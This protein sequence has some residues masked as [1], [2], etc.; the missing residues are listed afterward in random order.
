MGNP[1]PPRLATGTL[2]ELL[3]QVRL[4]QFDVQAAPPLK[5]SGNDLV[6][7][8]RREA[9]TIQ[10]KTATNRMPRRRNLPDHYDLL[11]LVKLHRDGNG[12][13]LD[14]S[15]IYI[16]QRNAVA[17][18]R[19]ANLDAFELRQNDETHSRRLIEQLFSRS[20]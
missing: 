14:S 2:G 11:V 18:I 15:R 16:L 7:F 12:L 4:L 6:A 3:V 13:H 5:D 8:L 17:T 1:L 9:R 19:R 20:R 10:V